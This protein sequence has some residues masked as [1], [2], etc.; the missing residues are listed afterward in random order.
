[1]LHPPSAEAKDRL[2]RDAEHLRT[3]IAAGK[4]NGALFLSAFPMFVPSL[5]WQNDRFYIKTAQ[6]CRFL[7]G[8]FASDVRHS[9]D[10]FAEDHGDAARTWK[11]LQEQGF[12]PN[13]NGGASSGKR[14]RDAEEGAAAAAAAAAAAPPGKKELAAALKRHKSIE[15]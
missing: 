14:P 5:S 1:L 10:G 6:K 2:K 3:H 12:A 4:K 15:G 13:D 11:L 9:S 8:S 7:A